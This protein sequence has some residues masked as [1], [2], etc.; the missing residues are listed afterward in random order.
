MAIFRES[1]PKQFLPINSQNGKSLLQNTLL[2]TTKL[3]NLSEPILI[4]NEKHRFIVAAEQIRELDIKPK[5]IIIEPFGRNTAPPVIFSALKAM[6]S[7]ANPHLLILSSDHQIHDEIKF[8]NVIEFGKKY[9]QLNK[10]VTFGVVPKYPETGYGY[11]KSEE[12]FDNKKLKASKILKFIEK[13]DL[14]KAKEYLKDPSFTWNSGIFLFRAKSII[15]E[16]K[17]LN[18]D[19]FGMCKE[20]LEKSKIDLDFLRLDINSFESCPNISLDVAIMEKTKKAMM[21]P[22]SVQWSDIGSWKSVWE[23]SEKDN[24]VIQ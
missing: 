6:E 14:N 21:V 16:M 2:R 23:N 1:F 8:R 13:P 4:C 19:L 5:S 18:P 11:I 10:L 22:L 15:E 7:E 3:K 17:I 12:P 20:T 9:S 24:N